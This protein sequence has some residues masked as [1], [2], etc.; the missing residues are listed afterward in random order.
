[1]SEGPPEK[2]SDGGFGQKIPH[3]RD[4]MGEFIRQ[5]PN[6][7]VV[8]PDVP[9]DEE[10]ETNGGDEEAAEVGAEEADGR[11]SD[12]QFGSVKDRVR[13]LERRR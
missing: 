5:N 2:P 9:D 7:N 13:E 4:I 10:E 11:D 1:M 3:P 8:D 12:E 6:T